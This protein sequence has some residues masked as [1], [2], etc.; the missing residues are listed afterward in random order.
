[1]WNLDEP[2]LVE[3]STVLLFAIPTQSMRD[4]LGKLKGRVTSKHLLVFTNKGIENG[5]YDLP[6][7]IVTDVFGKEIGESAVFLSG[8]SFAIEVVQKL[9]TGVS[10]AS[11]SLDRATWGTFNLLD[12]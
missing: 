6:C 10:V 3:D 12:D 2:G 7:D 1:V 9:P 8:P 5:T 4:V 11:H